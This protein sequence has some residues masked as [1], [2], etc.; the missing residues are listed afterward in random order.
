MISFFAVSTSPIVVDADLRN[1][2]NWVPVNHRTRANLHDR[3]HC[4]F[5]RVKVDLLVDD[6]GKDGDARGDPIG[7]AEI[8]NGQLP[9]R[10]VP[11]RA[12]S[13]QI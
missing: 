3:T 10:P 8:G 7:S 4:T 6:K 2:K 13:D 1:A 5:M 9:S 11:A 12:G